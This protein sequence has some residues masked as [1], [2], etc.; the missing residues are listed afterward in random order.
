[1][2]AGGCDVGGEDRKDNVKSTFEDEGHMSVVA[3][4][5]YIDQVNCARVRCCLAREDKE[6]LNEIRR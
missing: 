4:R 3:N 5:S 6:I 1:M 2:V